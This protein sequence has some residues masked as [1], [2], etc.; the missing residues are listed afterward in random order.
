MLGL[1]LSIPEVAIRGSGLSGS[2]TG[3]AVLDATGATRSVPLAVLDA[4]GATRTVPTA[5]LGAN[6]TSY[7]PI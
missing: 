2:A 3:F 5:V 6:G 4:T 1:G 7:T